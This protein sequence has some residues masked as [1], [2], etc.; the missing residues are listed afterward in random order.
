MH[1]DIRP[2][3]ASDH[4]AVVRLAKAVYSDLQITTAHWRNYD[5]TFEGNP[6]IRRRYVAVNSL[7]G[8]VVGFG[9]ISHTPTS[10]LPQ[11]FQMQIL[12]H[13]NFRRR[14]IG[15]AIF[16]QLTA[17]L[18]A[19]NAVSVQASVREEHKDAVAFLVKR[20]FKEA[21]RFWEL[22]LDVAEVDTRK[23]SATVERVK[24]QG[25]VIVTLAEE[26]RLNP[27]CLRSLYDLQ[28]EIGKEVPISGHFTFAPF[29]DF[30]RWF[31]RSNFLPD[32]FFIAKKGSEYIGISNLTL[33][34]V[35]E[36]DCLYQAQTGIL[37]KYRR[38]KIATALKIAAIEYA[39]RN[40]FRFIVTHN[41]SESKNMLALNEK[42]GFKRRL[43]IV[44]ME[45]QF[46]QN[47]P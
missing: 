2:F 3:E 7:T 42:L 30:V 28:R 6:F 17:D 5:R 47:E 37:A 39:Q 27:S 18:K 26:R 41:T 8:S 23:F 11:K 29:D 15:S 38:R 35:G 4:E 12:V 20:G 1:F 13:P 34:R 10:F 33:M 45:R 22:W 24:A 43:G 19:L 46:S 36:T 25:I 9:S 40:G 44:K 21:L 14:G 31:E 32:A 16:E